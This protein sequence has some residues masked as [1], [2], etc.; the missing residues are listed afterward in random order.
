MTYKN[1]EIPV[2]YDVG[3][4]HPDSVRVDIDIIGV[5][6]KTFIIPDELTSGIVSIHIKTPVM[7]H[8]K[9]FPIYGVVCKDIEWGTSRWTAD[10]WI[11][12]E[13]KKIE[14]RFVA[15]SKLMK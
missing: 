11:T 15:L 7:N 9:I 12:F 10:V 2:I 4:P 3:P 14:S 6:N 8:L 1:K 13:N 5:R